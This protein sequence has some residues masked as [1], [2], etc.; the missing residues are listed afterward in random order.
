MLIYLGFTKPNNDILG[1]FLV[2]VSYLKL[3]N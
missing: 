2:K 3:F 1:K